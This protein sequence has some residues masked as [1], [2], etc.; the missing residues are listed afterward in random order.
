MDGFSLQDV[1]LYPRLSGLW[2]QKLS[3]LF[4]KGV[5]N[6]EL[7]FLLGWKVAKKTLLILLNGFYKSLKT[8][9]GYFLTFFNY[10]ATL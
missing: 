7:I 5:K 4:S 8:K 1:S 9:E 2:V 10:K 6:S 3:C